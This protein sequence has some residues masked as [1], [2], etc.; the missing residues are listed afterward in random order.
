VEIIHGQAIPNLHKRVLNANDQ[1]IVAVDLPLIAA[2]PSC[3]GSLACRTLFVILALLTHLVSVV[4]IGVTQCFDVKVLLNGSGQFLVVLF[5]PTPNC[6][7]G[8]R[9]V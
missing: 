6:V 1:I 5:V 4:H 2:R 3:L 7:L 9:R 8:L